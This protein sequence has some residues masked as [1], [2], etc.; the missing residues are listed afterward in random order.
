MG[1]MKWTTGF[2]L[3][4]IEFKGEAGGNNHIA[5]AVGRKPAL[6]SGMNHF[7]QQEAFAAHCTKGNVEK[8]SISLSTSKKTMP[9]AMFNL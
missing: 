9:C 1:W 8:V 3:P 7:I 5:T 6:E 4:W 2:L